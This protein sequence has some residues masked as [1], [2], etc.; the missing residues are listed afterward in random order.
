MEIYGIL[1]KENVAKACSHFVSVLCFAN[2]SHG[3]VVQ[4][5]PS[6]KLWRELHIMVPAT[7]ADIPG[8][9]LHA[10]LDEEVIMLL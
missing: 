9:F 6:F 8:A 2:R 5:S 3:V 4:V 1:K 10:D 7:G